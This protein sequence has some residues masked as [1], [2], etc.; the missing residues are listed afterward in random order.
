MT[1]GQVGLK[2]KKGGNSKAQVFSTVSGFIL[3]RG[4][5]INNPLLE[6]EMVNCAAC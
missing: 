3:S 2:K 1:L 4:E 6:G 5:K